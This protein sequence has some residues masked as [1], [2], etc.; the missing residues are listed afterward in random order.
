MKTA[1]INIRTY[2]HVKKAAQKIAEELGLNLSTVLDA[3]LR[4]FIRTKEVY[5]SLSS[6]KPTR[7]LLN[8]IRISEKQYQTGD[9]KSFNE[10]EALTFIDRII[11]KSKKKR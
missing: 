5:F 8:S 9:F 2:P 10:S 11:A 4:Q 3:Y 6:E 7:K 1:P